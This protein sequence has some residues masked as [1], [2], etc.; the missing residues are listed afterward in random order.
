MFLMQA[1]HPALQTTL[2]LPSPEIGNNKN[3][4][5][6]VQIVRTIDGTPYSYVKP[7]RGR[8]Q[9]TWDFITTKEKA[10]E[11]KNVIKRYAG[12]VWKITDHNQDIFLGYITINPFESTGDGRAGGW[13]SNE[14]CT[15]S[16]SFEERV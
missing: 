11:T 2:L 6:T 1:P 4:T 8:R 7:K 13:P 15:F 9:F 10:L 3:L 5:S 16:I 14:A 12:N